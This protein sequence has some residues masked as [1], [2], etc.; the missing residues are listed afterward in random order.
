VWVAGD[1]AG[2]IE[3]GQRIAVTGPAPIGQRPGRFPTYA[4]R[5]PCQVYWPPYPF[6]V[7]RGLSRF[8]RSKAPTAAGARNPLLRSAR[9]PDRSRTCAT[10]ARSGDLRPSVGPET[11]AHQYFLRSARS[12][13]RS[14]TCARW[15]RRPSPISGIPVSSFGKVSRPQPHLGHVGSV[16]RPS[17]ISGPGDLRPSVGPETFAHQWVRRPSPIGRPGDLR[18]SVGPETFAHQWARTASQISAAVGSQIHRSAANPFASFAPFRGFRGPSPQSLAGA[19]R[20]FYD[21]RLT[22]RQAC[23][24]LDPSQSSS[25]ARGNGRAGTSHS[26]Y[27]ATD[28]VRPVRADRQD[29]TTRSMLAPQGYCCSCRPWP[30]PIPLQPSLFVHHPA[31]VMV[32]YHSRWKSCGAP[33]AM[34]H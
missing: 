7:F 5:T 30:S 15:A 17:P 27:T 33:T 29:P 11:F 19:R 20:P 14:R 12:P 28:G 21:T 34:I 18:P 16:W 10:W 25:L 2:T 32:V 31:S 13:D 22:C 4:Q 9:S 3:D 23:A 6:R 8:S 1:A 26:T 24:I